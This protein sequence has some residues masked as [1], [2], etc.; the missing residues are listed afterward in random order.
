VETTRALSILLLLAACGQ[1]K[2]PADSIARLDS[3]NED[4]RQ[5]AADDLR[6]D[7]GVPPEAI[8]PLMDHYAREQSPKVRGAILITL[9]R[10]GVPEAKPLIDQAIPTE[11][12]DMRRWAGRALKYWM[13]ANHQIAENWEFPDGWPYGQPGF[14]PKLPEK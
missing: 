12:R 4:E 11:D 14:P 1:P 7:S 2:T 10:S 5:S 8:R 6:T 9:G 3:P 13:I